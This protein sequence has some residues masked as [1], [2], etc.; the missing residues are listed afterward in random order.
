MQEWFDSGAKRINDGAG[1]VVHGD[2][3]IDNL[4]C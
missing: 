4:V 2:Y 3:K 1:S